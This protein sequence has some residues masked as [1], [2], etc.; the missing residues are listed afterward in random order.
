MHALFITV[1]IITTTAAQTSSALIS[2]RLELQRYTRNF[3]SCY[4]YKIVTEKNARLKGSSSHSVNE[5]KIITRSKPNF[6]VFVMHVNKQLILILSQNYSSIFLF[7]FFLRLIT[8]VDYIPFLC[9][10]IYF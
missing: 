7:S 1:N 5:Q 10:S 9:H 3:V 8:E 4:L 6:D 2:S